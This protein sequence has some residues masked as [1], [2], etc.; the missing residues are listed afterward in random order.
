MTMLSLFGLFGFCGVLF[1]WRVLS[2]KVIPLTISMRRWLLE[3]VNARS[4]KGGRF[5]DF[6]TGAF[7]NPGSTSR[8]SFLLSLVNLQH[9]VLFY[10]SYW[11]SFRSWRKGNLLPLGWSR[12][13]SLHHVVLV[14]KFAPPIPGVSPFTYPINGFLIINLRLVSKSYLCTSRPLLSFNYS[15]SLY[16]VDTKCL[17]L[18]LQPDEQQ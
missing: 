10:S 5:C 12:N 11:Y 13:K 6:L 14:L 16:S 17:A 8:C 3:N 4:A 15:W 18:L 1:T 7:P 9:Q 2:A